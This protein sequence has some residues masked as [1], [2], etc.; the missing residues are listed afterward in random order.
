[1]T[2]SIQAEEAMLSDIKLVRY[3]Q[4]PAENWGPQAKAGKQAP[5]LQ[6][7]KADR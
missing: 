3:Q 7:R 5:Q 4:N 1:M 6:E 2:R